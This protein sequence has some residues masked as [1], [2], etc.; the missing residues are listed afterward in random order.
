[1]L[2]Y[3]SN[4]FLWGV[5]GDKTLFKISCNRGLNALMFLKLE[6]D[7]IMF[8]IDWDVPP[9]VSTKYT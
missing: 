3:S 4:G 9:D 5:L 1:M 6:T 2:L 7:G 8:N